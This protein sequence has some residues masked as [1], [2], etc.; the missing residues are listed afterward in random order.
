[1]KNYINESIAGVRVRDD[2][3]SKENVEQ[4]KSAASMHYIICKVS[5]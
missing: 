5:P 2:A 4:D 3:A 1:M